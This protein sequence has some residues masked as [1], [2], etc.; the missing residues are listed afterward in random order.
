[1]NSEATMQPLP[2]FVYGMRMIG[3][4]NDYMWQEITTVL[5]DTRH[6]VDFMPETGSDAV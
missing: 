5:F 4:P 6:S 2:I 1:M 3:R